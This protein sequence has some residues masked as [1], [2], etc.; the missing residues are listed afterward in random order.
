MKPPKKMGHII[1]VKSEEEKFQRKLHDQTT[2]AAWL[3]GL[4]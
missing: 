1:H 3:R 2:T 4:C